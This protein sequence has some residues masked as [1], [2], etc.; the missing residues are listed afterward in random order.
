MIVAC[1]LTGGLSSR[2]GRDKAGVP[3]GGRTL[4]A[5]VRTAARDAGLP[6]R[7]IR[8]DLV[9]RCGPLGGVYTGL[10]RTKADAVLF[11]SCDMP[12]VTG[13]LLRG[14]IARLR[15]GTTAVF[16]KSQGRLGFPFLVRRR[17]L[18]TI[19][20]MLAC[21]EFR[22]QMLG[23]NLKAASFPVR[24]RNTAAVLNINTPQELKRAEELLASQ[25]RRHS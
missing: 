25:Q 5:R 23:K 8:Q 24:G 22:L 11:L 15:P 21:Q 4:L 16:A 10:R 3:L 1:I 17:G 7:V 6:V 13:D 18:E 2:M 14:I 12:F 20:T 9:P 19:Q